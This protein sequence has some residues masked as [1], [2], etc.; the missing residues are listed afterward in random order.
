[1]TRT[2][3]PYLAAVHRAWFE[4]MLEPS[5]I[6]QITGL[7]GNANLYP[8]AAGSAYPSPPEAALK[9]AP[10]Q[11]GLT[12]SWKVPL[13]EPDSS[14]IETSS[15]NISPSVCIRYAGGMGVFGSTLGGASRASGALRF[16]SSGNSSSSWLT[17]SATF[18]KRLP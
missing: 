5:P 9:Y 16:G 8:T 10:G 11:L 13:M 14:K 6:K 3:A 2:F 4:Y 17:A 1:M 12:Y 7:S 18:P 15:G